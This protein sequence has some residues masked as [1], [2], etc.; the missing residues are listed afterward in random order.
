MTK[1]TMLQ[2]VHSDANINHYSYFGAYVISIKRNF[3]FYCKRISKITKICNY[4][5]EV[6]EFLRCTNDF[7]FS[8]KNILPK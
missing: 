4:S 8:P 2:V 1:I 5:I 7:S 3:A 6:I